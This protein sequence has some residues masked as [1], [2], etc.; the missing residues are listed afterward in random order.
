MS[1]VT[2]NHR[3][4]LI[5]YIL[6]INNNNIQHRFCYLNMLCKGGDSQYRLSLIHT[7]TGN[8]IPFQWNRILLTIFI[9]RGE[10]LYPWIVVNCY[11]SMIIREEYCSTYS[12][13]LLTVI[14]PIPLC[15]FSTKYIYK[16]FCTQKLYI[17]SR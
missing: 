6:L 7:A 1:K 12:I 17:K 5:F 16:F 11:L 14:A 9:S 10:V 3:R 8:E 13:D 4:M 2:K 15:T